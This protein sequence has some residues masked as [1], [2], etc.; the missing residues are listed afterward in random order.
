MRPSFGV[1]PFPR[2]RSERV[3]EEEGKTFLSLYS[4]FFLLALLLLLSVVA[5]VFITCESA[6]VLIFIVFSFL[7]KK[8]SSRIK[9]TPFALFCF[10]S[11]CSRMTSSCRSSARLS[12]ISRIFT[13]SSRKRLCPFNGLSAGNFSGFRALSCAFAGHGT[14]NSI[15]FFR[16]SASFR[17]E[18]SGFCHLFVFSNFRGSIA[19]GSFERCCWNFCDAL[20]YIIGV[21]FFF[22][23][24]FFTKCA[25]CE[26]HSRARKLSSVLFMNDFYPIFLSISRRRNT[27]YI[28]YVSSSQPPGDRRRQRHRVHQTRVRLEHGAVVRCSN[29]RVRFWW[30]G[31][32]L[33]LVRFNNT[34]QKGGEG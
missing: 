20:R 1:P 11:L 14:F 31:V 18:N 21:L 15:A 7:V 16:N 22:F 2:S 26:A 27:T 9:S 12:F 10:L 33:L 29:V 30:R 17:K 5:F 19:C 3:E 8:I 28:L 23:S 4:F 32:L 6:I 13:C 24:V 34:K 25:S